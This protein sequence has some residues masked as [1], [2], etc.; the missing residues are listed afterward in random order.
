MQD[1]VA[2]NFAAALAGLGLRVALV[3]T[4]PSQSWYADSDEQDGAL[5]FPD[6]LATAHAGR[7]NGHLHDRMMSTPFENLRVIPHG[8]AGADEL[9][10]G[11]PPLLHAM[12]EA[13]I[14]VT[15]IAAPAMLEE[16]NATILAWSTRSVLWVVESGEVTEHEAREAAERLAMAGASPFGVAVVSGAG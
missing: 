3:A 13:D 16:S 5:T 7:L 2:A 14:D 6:F 4:E 10:D 15:V 12:A 8:E 11:L 9:L 1:S